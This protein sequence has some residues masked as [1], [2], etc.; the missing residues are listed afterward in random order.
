[1]A[2]VFVGNL[3]EDIKKS[4]LEDIFFKYGEIKDIQIKIPPRPP[5][6]AFITFDVSNKLY[7]YIV[8]IFFRTNVMLKMQF[9]AEINMNI[10]E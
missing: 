3:P 5:A 8:L 7:F 2:R 6:F 10:M 9:M 1:M 4:E